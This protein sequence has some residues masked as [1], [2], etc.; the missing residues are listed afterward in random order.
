MHRSPDPQ[1]SVSGEVTME[2]KV[3]QK[4]NEAPK[5][6]GGKPKGSPKTGGR[7]KGS[8]NKKSLFL[9][10]RLES[11]GCDLDKQLA[12]AILAKD[13]NMIEALQKLL[14]YVQPKL[15]DREAPVESEA[16]NDTTQDT[17][18]LIKLVKNNEQ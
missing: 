3:E 8:P 13:I 1:R 2:S 15:K 12:E 16:L 18:S 10:E 4:Q 11:H 5:K 9:R 6:R 14:P 17:D 7:Q